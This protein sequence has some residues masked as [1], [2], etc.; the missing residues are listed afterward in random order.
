M[1]IKLL[2][3]NTINRPKRKKI[4]AKYAATMEA[5]NWLPSPDGII[6]AKDGTLMQGQHRLEAVI[7]SQKQ[8]TMIVWR[9]VDNDIF[10]V[11]DR[12]AMRTPSDA[13][14]ISKDAA[15]VGA[16]L[17]R[18]CNGQHIAPTDNDIHEYFEVISSELDMLLDHCNTNAKVV[19]SAA[20]RAA[21]CVRLLAGYNE[22]YILK[23]YRD[24]CLGNIHEL[25][26]IA[27]SF[28]VSVY[29][30]KVRSLGGVQ[31]TDI[32][33]RMWDVMDEDKADNA[34]VSIRNAAT[35][36]NKAV[37]IVNTAMR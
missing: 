37:K 19:S 12:G 9:N 26:P 31:Q 2:E 8:V 13:L 18:L 1:A 23:T 28:A 7:Q 21:C 5:G 4:I 11:L 14:G 3:G 33:A 36:I 6:V 29:Q 16:T 10:K 35:R 32:F 27:Q 20:A 22:D 34:R 30:G 25:P 24:L 17:F 15:A